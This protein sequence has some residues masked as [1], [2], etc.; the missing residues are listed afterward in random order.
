MNESPRL[1]PEWIA[2]RRTA[3]LVIDLQV[4]F[5]APEGAMARSGADIAP[6]R[7][8]Q[9][10]IA[11]L[12][13]AARTADVPCIFSRAVTSPERQTAVEEEARGRHGEPAPG[14]CLAGTHGV[15]FVAPRPREGELVITKQRYSVFPGT[16][17]AERLKAHGVDTIVFCGLT[18]ECC[19]QSSAWDAFERDFH[20]FIAEDAVAA[21]EPALH[22][23]ALRSL[24]LSGAILAPAAA[25]AAAWK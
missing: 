17:L 19:V 14:I 25:F 21:Y 16:G 24:E 10:R 5:A 12:V 18:T 11:D 2:P 15:D 23:A 9:E 7:A 20:V 4:D 3:L 8:A 6:A 1:K 13:E 22:Q